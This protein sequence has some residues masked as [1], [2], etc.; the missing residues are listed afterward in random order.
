[1]AASRSAL[2]NKPGTTVFIK[3][4][5]ALANAFR[6]VTSDASNPDSV[7][8]S[9]AD[10]QSLGVVYQAYAAGESGECI[11]HGIVMVEAG[12]TVATGDYVN[13]STAGVAIVAATTKPIRGRC[14]VGGASGELISVDLD[15][16]RSVAP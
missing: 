9:A 5:A 13:A 12:G 1:M 14:L 10:D 15:D 3:P 11:I 16:R 7:T 6:F 2:I 8:L 4:A